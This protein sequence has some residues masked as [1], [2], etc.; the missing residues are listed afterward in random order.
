MARTNSQIES[1]SLVCRWRKSEEEKPCWVDS[2]VTV[3]SLM[4][5]GTSL[6]YR[7]CRTAFGL[8]GHRC[9][10]AEFQQARARVEN[11]LALVQGSWISLEQGIS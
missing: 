7:P 2:T 4:P 6:P 5:A 8:T 1:S 9:Y 3:L 11:A 10:L